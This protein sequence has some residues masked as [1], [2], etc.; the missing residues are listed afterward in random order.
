MITIVYT[1]IFAVEFRLNMS[2]IRVKTQLNTRKTAA[3]IAVAETST[4]SNLRTTAEEL[5]DAH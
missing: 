3:S 5:D 2:G 1:K 4:S